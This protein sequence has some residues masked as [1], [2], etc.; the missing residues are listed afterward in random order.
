MQ[1]Q[2]KNA[3]SEFIIFHLDVHLWSGRKKAK[4]EE[5]GI[6]PEQF[7][8]ELLS[9]GHK[10]TFDPKRLAPFAAREKR[11]QRILERY[12]VQMPF[13]VLVPQEL[14]L[15]CA[16]ELDKE[17]RGG[18]QDIAELI[19]NWTAIQEAWIEKFPGKE[20]I[21]RQHLTP[22]EDV[23]SQIRF[24]YQAFKVS[25]VEATDPHSAALLQ[26]GFV[27]ARDGLY[28]QLV[29]GV[30]KV[31]A[32]VLKALRENERKDRRTTT[33]LSTLAQKLKSLAFI[34][35][36]VVP[37][38]EAIQDFLNGL[39]QLGSYAPEE[40]GSL[41]RFLKILADHKVLC[42]KLDAGEELVPRTPVDVDPV[43]VADSSKSKP[44]KPKKETTAARQEQVM[45]F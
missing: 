35:R 24:A 22:K 8:A 33:P 4:A 27:T 43:T 14:A 38:Y 18:Q 29:L 37:L 17:V 31:S 5:F 12:G 45:L 23:E 19:S 9:L 10:K 16:T 7:E 25:A 20:D 3:P 39:P 30:S 2:N 44:G 6:T 1:N 26:S 41:E 36:R 15:Q 40:V 21:L 34:D 32:Q 28:G 42:R 11:M 13:G